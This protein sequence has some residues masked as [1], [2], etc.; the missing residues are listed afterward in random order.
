MR[1]T[2]A[3]NVGIGTTGPTAM[4]D[5]FLADWGGIQLVSGFGVAQT[6][7]ATAFIELLVQVVQQEKR[8][9]GASSGVGRFLFFTG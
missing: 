7:N 4:L 2:T 3:G 9:N 8:D 1:I 5:A 6:V